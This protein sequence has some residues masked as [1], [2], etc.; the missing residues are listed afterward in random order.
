MASKTKSPGFTGRRRG[1]MLNQRCALLPYCQVE[2]LARSIAQMAVNSV[3]WKSFRCLVANRPQSLLENLKCLF[4][5]I[6]GK[7]SS[8]LCLIDLYWSKLKYIFVNNDILKAV[9]LNTNYNDLQDIPR[10]LFSRGTFEEDCDPWQVDKHGRPDKWEKMCILS[11]VFQGPER[12]FIT[13]PIKRNNSIPW[14][15]LI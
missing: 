10:T 6:A 8:V 7:E 11:P 3:I 1:N 13:M 5:H 9:E 12:L 4:L 2:E 14:H 15:V